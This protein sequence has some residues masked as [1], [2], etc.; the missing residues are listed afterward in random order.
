MLKK[1][2]A[3]SEVEKKSFPFLRFL[4]LIYEEN[5]F[6]GKNYRKKHLS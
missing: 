2:K 6:L 5:S 4:S 3:S 1:F